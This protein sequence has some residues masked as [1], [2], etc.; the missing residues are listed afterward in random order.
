MKERRQYNGIVIAGAASG[1]GKTL[2]SLGLMEALRLRGLVL[3]PFKAGPDYIDA[4]LHAAVLGR[5]SY[6]LDTW[7]MGVRGV[8]RTFE[9]ASAHADLS[10]VEGVMGLYDGVDGRSE[11]GST[12]HLAK[13]LKLPVI[14][15]IDAAKTARSAGAVITG[16]AAFDR[17]VDIRWVIFNRVGSERHLQILMASIPR[18]LG[19]RYLGFLPRDAEL[20]MPQRHLGL[21]AAGDMGREKWQGF[22][23]KA[24]QV[25]EK[26]ID[27]DGLLA[28]VRKQTAQKPIEGTSKKDRVTIAVARDAAFSFYYEENLEFL[29]KNGARLIF[30]S[31]L[32]D[33]RL[34]EGISG[35]YLGGGFPELFADALEAN[36]SM[37]AEI[38]A[39]SRKGLPVFAECGGMIY[40]GSRLANKEGGSLRMAGVFPWTTR[41]LTKRA[42]L[43]YREVEVSPGSPM[44][45]QGGTLRGH[46]FHYSTIKEPGPAIGRVFKLTDGRREGFTYKNCLAT[47]IHLHFASNPAFAKGFVQL[48]A[49]YKKEEIK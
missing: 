33:S 4:G 3:A 2:V 14:L 31:P 37:R 11:R 45:K 26:S 23:K 8:K 28:G 30:F 18:G 36:R 12:A 42:A 29:R 17:A 5:P 20:V 6:N 25:M 38:K 41:M 40:L 7:M 34:P 13:T 27:I 21:V 32:I 19:L 43:G 24:A 35:L 44:L 15:V 22:L 1:T 10:I 49:R 16:F 48:C 46:E 9:A 47:Y 39:V